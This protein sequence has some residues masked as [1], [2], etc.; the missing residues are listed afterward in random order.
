MADET[1]DDTKD[2][3]VAEEGLSRKVR[4]WVAFGR[5]LVIRIV[6]VVVPP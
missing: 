4:R 3:P 2:L 5:L 1:K 6:G